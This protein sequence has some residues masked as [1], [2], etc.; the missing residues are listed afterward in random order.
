MT[1][2]ISYLIITFVSVLIILPSMACSVPTEL[3]LLKAEMMDMNLAGIEQDG[4][5]FARG[6]DLGTRNRGVTPRLRETESTT[7][8]LSH[9][10]TDFKSETK[11][12]LEYFSLLSK[13]DM[14][15]NYLSSNSP[16]ERL[17]GGLNSDYGSWYQMLMFQE[18][19]IAQG[20]MN[21]ANMFDVAL[22][23]YQRDRSNEISHRRN[24]PRV[25]REVFDQID[26]C[27]A[28]GMSGG[29]GG[30]FGTGTDLDTVRKDCESQISLAT[31]LSARG[32]VGTN[33]CEWG[34]L[35]MFGH[36]SIEVPV[37][38]RAMFGDDEICPD[39]LTS[40]S[41]PTYALNVT[42]PSFSARQ[43]WY[44][45]YETAILDLQVILDR[46]AVENGGYR[47]T[48]AD[49]AQ[50]NIRPSIKISQALITAIEDGLDPLREKR[51]VVHWWA[52]E[53]ANAL[54]D[55]ACTEAESALRE[56]ASSPASSTEHKRWRRK[57]DSVCGVRKEIAEE[58]AR[59]AQS[60]TVLARILVQGDNATRKQA[61]AVLAQ[62]NDKK[63]R[64]GP[65]SQVSKWNFGGGLAADISEADSF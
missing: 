37:R 38:M 46:A 19:T 11:L 9:D 1:K 51:E 14:E 60:E 49:L 39:V 45:E 31:Y 20:G 42:P 41:L 59:V 47:L 13:K 55:F 22:A 3:S 54:I 28:E 30:F 5:H 43:L 25:A 64:G 23:S 58:M 32:A 33:N 48:S 61:R 6:N 35:V 50:I 56:A 27:I 44:D 21:I 10:E 36:L 63:V 4:I 62:A 34:S 7:S 15:S 65:A 26:A 53:K 17:E 12:P 18:P 40:G 29:I 57:V 52:S 2:R 24:L 16:K 8:F